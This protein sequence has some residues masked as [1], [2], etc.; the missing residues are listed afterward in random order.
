MRILAYVM[1]Q[2]KNKY[3]V[4]AVHPFTFHWIYVFFIID[5]F[6]S[7][8]IP[9]LQRRLTTSLFLNLDSTLETKTQYLNIFTLEDGHK[10]ETCSGY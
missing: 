7:L 3:S 9:S 4:Q 2:Q 10:T 6:V 1:L 8:A 5:T